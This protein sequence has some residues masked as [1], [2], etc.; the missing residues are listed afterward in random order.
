MTG[1]PCLVQEIFHPIDSVVE[2]IRVVRSDL[3]IKLALLSWSE[4]NPVALKD[5]VQVVVGPPVCG[6]LV[7]DHADTLVKNWLRSAPTGE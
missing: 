4:S 7:I 5:R 6:R 3:D 1:R 2:K